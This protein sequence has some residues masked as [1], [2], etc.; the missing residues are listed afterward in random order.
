M[1]VPE[2]AMHEND[3]AAAGENQIGSSGE[4]MPM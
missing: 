2:A 4:V 3:F 1:L